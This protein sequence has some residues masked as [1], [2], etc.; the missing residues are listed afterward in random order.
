MESSE[1]QAQVAEKLQVNEINRWNSSAGV[2]KS[3]L[4]LYVSDKAMGNILKEI[5]YEKYQK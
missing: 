2:K 1:N 5:A 3:K 4:D